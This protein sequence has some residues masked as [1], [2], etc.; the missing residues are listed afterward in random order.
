MNSSIGKAP[1]LYEKYAWVILSIIGLLTIVGGVQHTL[2]SNSDPTTTENIIGMTI[3]EFQ[4]SNI[5]FYNLYDYFFRGGGWSD[6]AFAFL[7]LVI[8]ATAY[9]K[10]ERWAWYTLWAVPVFF[11][12]HAAIT[13]YVGPAAAGLLPFITVFTMLSIV[14]LLLPIRRFFPR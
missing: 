10:E 8:S 3:T 5:E 12:G 14:G 6:M 4:S 2:G 11:L 13:I 7:A 9:R 1:R